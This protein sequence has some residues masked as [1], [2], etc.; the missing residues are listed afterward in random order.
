MANYDRSKVRLAG[1]K[2]PFLDAVAAVGGVRAMARE[3][4]VT[5]QSVIIWMARC[6]K[7]KN[8]LLPAERVPTISRATGMSPSAF[9]PDLWLPEHQF[10]R[11]EAIDDAAQ[12]E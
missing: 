4:G 5:R 3:L 12:K 8:F 6:R 1:K 10:I 2:H 9:R 11:K 7:D